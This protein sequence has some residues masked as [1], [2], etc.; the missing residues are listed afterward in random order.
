MLL[1]VPGQTELRRL[2]Q[3]SVVVSALTDAVPP[4]RVMQAVGRID[5]FSA[6]VGP[7]SGVDPPDPLV[8]AD[9][10]VREAARS[11]VRITGYACGLG[12]EGPAGS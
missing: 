11:V 8:V 12:V 10:E 1:Y 3:E 6:I 2:A 7:E 9:P 5:L 4:S